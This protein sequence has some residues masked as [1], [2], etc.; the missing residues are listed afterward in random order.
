M[1]GGVVAAHTDSSTAVTCVEVDPLAGPSELL[2][3][4]KPAVT[5][6]EVE[7]EAAPMWL[8]NVISEAV[9]FVDVEPLAVPRVD[10]GMASA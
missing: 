9:S 2:T 1:P 4:T 3:T 6:V 10:A 7:P 5:L 8:F